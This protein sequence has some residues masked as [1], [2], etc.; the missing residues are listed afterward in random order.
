MIGFEEQKKLFN[1]IGIECKRKIEILVIGG[2]AMLFYNFSKIVTKDIDIVLLSE[3]DRK[4]L[5]KI[6]KKIG[7]KIEF[8]PKRKGE[9]YK[10]V[11]K[12]YSL[13]LFANNVFKLK[14]SEGIIKRIREKIEFGNLTVSIISPED[15][16]LS[17]S[18]TERIGDKEDVLLII[19]ETNVKWDTVINECVWQ[20]KNGDY[21]FC[22]YLYDF[23]DELV[24]QFNVKLPINVVKKIKKLFKE[25]MN[26]LELTKFKKNR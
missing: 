4:Y 24:H 11:F 7:F 14:I 20:T 19:K 22:F 25:S 9:P 17:K 3:K 5:I 18:I 26:K 15:I 6:L 13:D 2:S 12:D 23:L 21:R 10:L 8:S 1:L 16:I